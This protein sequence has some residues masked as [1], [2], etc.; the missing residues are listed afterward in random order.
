M[1][2]SFVIGLSRRD[3]MAQI[4]SL[5]I[6]DISGV[7]HRESE[8]CSNYEI[9]I[10][11][12]RILDIVKYVLDLRAIYNSMRDRCDVQLE[13]E[14]ILDDLKQSRIGIYHKPQNHQELLTQIQ[15]ILEQ[16]T[17]IHG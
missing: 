13:Y 11:R 7:W 4:S 1:S 12:G 17:K 8:F 3:V 6:S 9:K 16:D 10:D 15:Q 14:D 2:K 5:Y